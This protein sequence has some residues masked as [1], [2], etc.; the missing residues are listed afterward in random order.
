M[1]ARRS[2]AAEQHDQVR[3]RIYAGHSLGG[4]FGCYTL[5]TQPDTFSGYVIGSPS[6]YW[7]D[8]HVLK[9][10]EAYLKTHQDL[11]ATLFLGVGGL[12]DGPT[13]PM[14]ANVRKLESLLQQG[15]YP[16]LRLASRTFPDETHLTVWSTNL[17]HGLVSVL[18]RPAP[19]ATLGAVYQKA[20]RES[21]TAP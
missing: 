21:P 11:S 13:N 9:L 20:L 6:L 2:F 18:G 3:Q 10:A 1:S 4:L 15:N 17:I 16:H 12:E 7:N 19:D 14:V 5:F 8:Q